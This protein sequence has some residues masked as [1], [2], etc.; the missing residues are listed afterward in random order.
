MGTA[1]STCTKVLTCDPGYEWL[2]E[3]S[4]S[5]PSPH[6]FEEEYSP[7]QPQLALRVA[8]APIEE[9]LGARQSPF[10]AGDEVAITK[11]QRVP[12]WEP[13]GWRQERCAKQ[14]AALDGGKVWPGPEESRFST[15]QRF[16]GAKV[17][18]SDGK[19]GL[20]EHWCLL[21][22]AVA[23]KDR[24]MEKT[25][26]IVQDADDVAAYAHRFND[27]LTRTCGDGDPDAL[28]S[29]RV[30]APVAC[31]VIDGCMPEVA[32]PGESVTL[33]VLPANQIRKFLFEGGEDF[34]EL[35]QAFFHY[36]AWSSGGNELL[37]DLQGLQDDQDILLVDPVVL[38]T[39][40]AAA[41][42]LL[43]ALMSTDPLEAESVGRAA[44]RFDLWHPRC[45][46]ICKSFDPQRRSIHARR[47]CGMSL[48]SCGVGGA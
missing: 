34:I 44:K 10:G 6:K 12:G 28:P 37:G 25:K 38:R 36:V 31:F 16:W 30:S 27:H 20:E 8:F 47:A 32:Q 43:G 19:G 14:H 35:P 1:I 11:L 45:G 9:S 2:E 40:K 26:Q 13:L 5:R 48:P 4:S 22:V 42:D 3:D 39:A 33:T 15:A 24:E 17:M 41:K 18:S 23:K 7:S 29:V 21:Q 46:Q